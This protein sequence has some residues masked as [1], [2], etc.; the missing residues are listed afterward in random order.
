MV[1]GQIDTLISFYLEKR[2][3][4][5]WNRGSQNNCDRIQTTSLLITSPMPLTTRQLPT[6]AAE[7]TEN[8]CYLC[9]DLI[10]VTVAGPDHYPDPNSKG[11][12]QL[13]KP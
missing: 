4:N 9:T 12:G 2:E 3:K 7:S 10:N 6:A 13:P 8:L 11:E 5:P 1:T